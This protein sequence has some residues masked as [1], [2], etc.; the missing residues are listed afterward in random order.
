MKGFLRFLRN[1]LDFEMICFSEFCMHYNGILLLFIPLAG[2]NVNDHDSSK[3]VSPVYRDGAIV[4]MVF[5]AISLGKL[6][7]LL[8]VNIVK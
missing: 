5:L 7:F 6:P 8:A 4:A 3:M 1:I 2:H